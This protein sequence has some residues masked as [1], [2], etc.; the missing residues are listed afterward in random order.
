MFLMIMEKPMIG[1]D[2]LLENLKLAII[3]AIV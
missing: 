1:K 3:K 2:A